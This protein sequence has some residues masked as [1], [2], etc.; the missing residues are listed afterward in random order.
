MLAVWNVEDFGQARIFVAAQRRINDMVGNDARVIVRIADTPQRVFCH[1]ASLGNAETDTIER[2]DVVSSSAPACIW[3][4][5]LQQR[6]PLCLL[7][8]LGDGAFLVTIDLERVSKR[9]RD[10]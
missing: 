7:A 10:V 5:Q 6:T 8:P 9:R 1:T 4:I 2:H 3:A